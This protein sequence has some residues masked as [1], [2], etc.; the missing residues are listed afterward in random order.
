MVSST[1]NEMS[2]KGII[3]HPFYIYAFMLRLDGIMN[4]FFS[5][6]VLLEGVFSCDS[7]QREELKLIFEMSR[8]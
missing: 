4:A 1:C 8:F 3:S 6:Y 7:P 5:L 2:L